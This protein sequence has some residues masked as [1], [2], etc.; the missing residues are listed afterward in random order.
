MVD[1]DNAVEAAEV[2]GRNA[3]IA[4]QRKKRS[5]STDGQ[6]NSTSAAGSVKTQDNPLA[7]MAETGLRAR[8]L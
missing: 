3:N 7:R 2:R 8:N 1:Y 5:G 6:A 4:A